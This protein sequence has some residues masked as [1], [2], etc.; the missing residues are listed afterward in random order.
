LFFFE[1]LGFELRATRWLG[2]V[3][4]PLEP[5]FE[6]WFLPSPEFYGNWLFLLFL[7][8]AL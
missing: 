3:A 1:V 2:A 6:N 8:S 7:I 5:V 4:L